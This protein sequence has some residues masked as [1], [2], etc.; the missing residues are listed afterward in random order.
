MTNPVSQKK[1][2]GQARSGHKFSE[3]HKGT[4]SLNIPILI[5]KVAVYTP[6]LRSMSSNVKAIPFI[7]KLNR[8]IC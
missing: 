7:V 4:F 8:N 5:I 3:F 1:S 2:L 6:R